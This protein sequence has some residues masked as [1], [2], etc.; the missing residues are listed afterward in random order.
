MNVNKVYQFLK[1]SVLFSSDRGKF[2]WELGP[3]DT[4]WHHFYS[5]HSCGHVGAGAS[6]I[7]IGSF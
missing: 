4:S 3:G 5:E 1:I 6:L 2:F 7:L